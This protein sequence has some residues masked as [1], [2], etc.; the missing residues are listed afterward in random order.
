MSWLAKGILR[1]ENDL[2]QEIEL[3]TNKCLRPAEEAKQH[4]KLL[5]KTLKHRDNMKLDYE[6]YLSRAEHARKKDNRTAKEEAALE[7][8]EANLAQAQI[9]YQT[10]DEH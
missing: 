3:I 1:R 9:S 7:T 4:T 8:H 10:A 2:A 5:Q 6:R